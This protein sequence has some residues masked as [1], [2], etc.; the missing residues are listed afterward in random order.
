MNPIAII[1]I[2]FLLATIMALL[3]VFFRYCEF[4]LKHDI[5]FLMLGLL[6]FTLCYSASLVLE[7]S[8]ITHS[9]EPLEDL[10]GALIP[11]WWAFVFYSL[12][13]GML[14]RDLRISEE[15]LRLAHEELYNFNRHLENKVRERTEELNEKNEKLLKAEKL[16]AVG[17][18]A[19]RVAHELRNPLTV[20]G[21]MVRRLDQKISTDDPNKRYL[22]IILAETRVLENKVSEII[23][24]KEVE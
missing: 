20:V 24:V 12:L 19:N 4:S 22:N 18:M 23:K 11:M 2:I 3:I 7:W 13:Q 16:A 8:G 6:V 17:K 21:G 1:D 9:I 10:I 5:R 14:H 15:K